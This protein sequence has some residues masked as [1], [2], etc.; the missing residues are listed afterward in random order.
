[1]KYIGKQKDTITVQRR[2]FSKVFYVG[3]V[4]TSMYIQYS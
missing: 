2:C 3:I 4:Y 1:M